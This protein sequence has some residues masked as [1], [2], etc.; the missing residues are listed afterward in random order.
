MHGS[1]RQWAEGYQ[2]RSRHNVD[3]VGLSG[4]RWR[5]TLRGGAAPLAELTA[6]RL[7]ETAAPDVVLVS[8]IVD[9]AHLLALLRRKLD[10]AT[11]VVVYQHESQLLYP[12]RRAGD[13]E[14]ALRNWLSWCA[15]DL[16]LFNSHYHRDALLAELPTFLAGLPEPSHSGFFDEVSTRFEVLPIGLDLA[17]PAGSHDSPADEG[18]GPV[19]LWPHRWEPDKAPETFERALA[20]LVERQAPFRLVLAGEDP[21]GGNKVASALRAGVAERFADHVDAV[22][23]FDRDHYQRLMATADLVVSCAEHDFFGV[24]VVEAVTA[25]ARPLLPDALVY[26]EMIPSAWHR[27][28]LYQRGRFGTALIEAVEGFNADRAARL[29]EVDGLAESMS[30]FDWSVVAPRYDDRLERLT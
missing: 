17:G 15:A 24:G 10:P 5:W 30:R 27:A 16:V 25:G 28:V 21:P 19:I 6:R 4:R 18:R 2:A 26:P 3:L 23:P 20:K 14:A 8:G 1:H 7:Q 9:V 12:G 13:Q 11:P 29:A 22:G